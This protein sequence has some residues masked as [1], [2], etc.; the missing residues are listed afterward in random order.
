MLWQQL[1][2]I[3]VLIIPPKGK[4]NKE[5]YAK[6]IVDRDNI[7]SGLVCVISAMEASPTF[8]KI[9]GESHPRLKHSMIPHIA[10]YYYFMDKIFGLMH[11]RIQ[12]YFPF[13]VQI[14]VNGHEWLARKM[15]YHGIKYEKDDNCFTWIEDIERAQ[16]FASKFADIK[17]SRILGAFARKVNPLISETG[18]YYFITDQFE[19]STDVMF[20]NSTEF[21]SLFD[22]LLEQS[23][24]RFGPRDILTFVGKRFDGRFKGD[25]INSSKKYYWGSRIKH[26]IRKNWM[27]MYNKSGSVLRIETVINNPYDFKVLRPGIRKGEEVYGWYPLAKGIKNL[28]RY[29]E[30]GT[31]ANSRYLNALSVVDNPVP[32]SKSLK[33]L[34]EPVKYKNI[35]Y[36]GFN[37]VCNDSVKLFKAVMNGN[38]ISFGFQNKD[39]RKELYD[40][41]KTDIEKKRLAAKITR[42]F[43]KLKAHKMIAKVPRSRR[44]IITEKGWSVMGSAINIYD[45]GWQKVLYNK[46]A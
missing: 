37:P 15:S 29:I 14:H 22:K 42:L 8:K 38:Y 4:Y 6:M 31:A 36:T 13:T 2:S 27:K 39:I 41:P 19:C 7:K 28:Y 45:V 18:E 35:K 24:R 30:I 1:K 23:T 21:E 11:V 17:W 12:T 32:A 33:L 5:E 9:Y 46:T 20:N 40:H 3:I 43:K 25:Q 44:W 34:V 26:W 10:L 16:K